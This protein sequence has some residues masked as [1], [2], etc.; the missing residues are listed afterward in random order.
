VDKDNIQ[1]P[2]QPTSSYKGNI[3]KWDSYNDIASTLTMPTLEESAAV[4]VI[5]ESVRRKLGKLHILEL[6]QNLAGPEM[7]CYVDIIP[8]GTSDNDVIKVFNSYAD[9]P[10][11]ILTSDKNLHRELLGHSLFVKVKKGGNDAVR[12]ITKAIKHRI[13][14]VIREYW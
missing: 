3:Q 11:V 13:K 9:F 7:N 1:K 12:I 6:I 2:K 8:S 5:D 14:I 4:I 10:A